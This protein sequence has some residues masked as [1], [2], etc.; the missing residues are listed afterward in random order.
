MEKKYFNLGTSD[1]NS[2]I[3][4]VRIVFGLICILVAVF[5]VI[6]N[7]SYLKNNLTTWVTIIFLIIF[8]IYQIWSGLGRTRVFIE[9]GTKLIRLKK[10]PVLPEKNIAAVDI[11]NIEL[12]PLSIFLFLKS[13]KKLTLRFGTTYPEIIDV[14]KDAVIIFCEKNSISFE[15]MEEEL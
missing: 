13:G 11:K 9:I 7:V 2:L 12:Y 5:W 6:F 15:I 8:G 1:D 4:T 10:N 14:V 3:K